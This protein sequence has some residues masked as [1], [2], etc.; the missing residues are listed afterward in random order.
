[1][2]IAVEC[3][4]E[5][6]GQSAFMQVQWVTGEGRGGSECPAKEDQSIEELKRAKKFALDKIVLSGREYL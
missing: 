3:V 2:P 6:R 4:S 5:Q 1:M